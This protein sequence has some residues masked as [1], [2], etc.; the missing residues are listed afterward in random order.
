MNAVFRAMDPIYIGNDINRAGAE[1]KGS[2]SSVFGCRI[3]AATFLSTDGTAR[4]L[5]FGDIDLNENRRRDSIKLHIFD[6]D[7]IDIEDR[8]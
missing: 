7:T 3:I 8:F 4:L 1:I 6:L 2:P 5:S